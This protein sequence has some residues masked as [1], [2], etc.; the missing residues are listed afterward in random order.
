MGYPNVYEEAQTP[1]KG[2]AV[3]IWTSIPD[4]QMA[5]KIDSYLCDHKVRC[6]KVPSHPGWL[7][8]PKLVY[9]HLVVKCPWSY[10]ML[11]TDLY[12]HDH[13]V[14]CIGMSLNPG[15]LAIP[16]LVYH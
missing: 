4:I 1:Q 2:G 7:V 6:S 10:P 12:P 16:K 13:K 3:H 8:I 5:R 14:R 15:Y 9:H 11:W